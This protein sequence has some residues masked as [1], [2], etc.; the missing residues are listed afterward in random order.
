MALDCGVVSG[1]Q[2][3]GKRRRALKRNFARHEKRASRS[4][5]PDSLARAF[6]PAEDIGNLFAAMFGT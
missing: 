6:E 2:A 3:S 1:A 4:N 5:D